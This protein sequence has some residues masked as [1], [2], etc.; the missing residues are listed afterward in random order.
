M[1]AGPW[2]CGREDLAREL[3]TRLMTLPWMSLSPVGWR[4]ASLAARL[5]GAQGIRMPDAL[6][7]AAAHTAGATC[8]L[9][10]DRK[11]ARVQGLPF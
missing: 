10:N 7:L 11:L 1:L 2:R 9:T 8:F 4:E 5:R 3:E 6:I